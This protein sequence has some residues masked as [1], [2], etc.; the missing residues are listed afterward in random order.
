M[1]SPAA[2]ASP[3]KGR[4]GLRLAAWRGVWGTQR[5]NPVYAARYRHLTTRETNPLTPTEA[6][7]VIAAAILRQ[8][9]AVVTTR[10]PWNPH[11]ATH[12]TTTTGSAM[13][14]TAA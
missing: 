10:Q 4:P 13:I 3:V 6:Q 12:G 7:A 11:I 8:L 2:P 9:H 1:L 14:S 5:A